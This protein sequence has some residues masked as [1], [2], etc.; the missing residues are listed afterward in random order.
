MQSEQQTEVM[1]KE[2]SESYKNRCASIEEGTMGQK[3][4]HK[5]KQATS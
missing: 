1:K 2:Q 3:V 4:K 5:N